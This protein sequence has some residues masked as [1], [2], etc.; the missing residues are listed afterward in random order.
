MRSGV[1]RG[2]GSAGSCRLALGDQRLVVE[3]PLAPGFA[4]VVGMSTPLTMARCQE[5]AARTP[6]T[7]EPDEETRRGPEPLY[8]TRYASQRRADPTG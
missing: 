8:L 6:S 3:A 4:I 5:L 2:H 7:D 1:S